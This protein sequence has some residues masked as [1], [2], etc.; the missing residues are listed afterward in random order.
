VS[1]ATPPGGVAAQITWP[2]PSGLAAGSYVLWVEAAK[3]G[4]FNGT[5]NSTTYPS[6]PAS[7]PQGILWTGYGEAFRGQPSIVYQVPFSIAS[8]EDI[9]TTA[10]YAG[11]GDPDGADGTLRPPDATITTD[12]PGSGASRLQLVDDGGTMYRVRVDARNEVDLAPPGLPGGLAPVAIATTSVTLAFVAPGDDG[13][14]GKV[15]SYE[16]YYRANS[17]LTADNLDDAMTQ[18]LPGVVKPVDP[19]GTQTFQLDGLLPETDYWIGVRAIDKCSN[20]SDLAIAK[21]TTANR[22]SGEVDACFIATAAYGS[23]MANDVEQLRH[24]RDAL[25][26]SNVLGE[27]AVET[28]YTF[29]P[30]VAGVVGQ[31]ELLR[32]TARAALAPVVARVRRVTY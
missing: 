14:V 32:A 21:V 11:Y 26:S 30:P 25:L 13:Q 22:M 31:S 1:Q 17:P 20:T 27:L 28:Y 7:G 23:V 15:S 6:P 12:T 8:S 18:K 24:F 19:G 10:S 29:G 3:E 4:D 2:I 16:I 5:Y 9:E